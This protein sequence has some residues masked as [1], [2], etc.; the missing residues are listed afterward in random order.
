MKK[1]LW[2]FISLVSSILSFHLCASDD[3]QSKLELGQ[4]YRHDSLKFDMAGPHHKPNIISEL[5]YKNLQVYL[6]TLKG[7]ISNGTYIGVVDLAYGDIL[8]G[9]VRDSDYFHNN[10]Q[11]E[12][13]RSISKIHGDYTVDASAKIGRIFPL[14]SGMTFTP[15]VGYGAFWQN[16]HMTHAR[17]VIPHHHHFHLNSTY[18][19][20]WSAP[21][22]DF[23]FSIPLRKALSLDLGYTFFYP[24][25][26]KGKGHW[27]LRHLH[28]TQKNKTWDSYG[29][30]GDIHLRWACT[31]RLEL[32]FGV[33]VSHFMAKNGR[34]TSH[35]HSYTKKH[36]K[37]VFLFMGGNERQPAKRAE[38]TCADY[39]LS[40]SYAF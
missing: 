5:D 4:G 32:G 15:S 2:S 26:Y 9:K 33:G 19:T 34:V 16:L 22:V 3:V 25:N 1:N 39:V 8:N 6:T 24:V 38:R 40:I 18:K 28:F 11:G 12:F 17:Q 7:T 30:K 23:R 21:F 20:L 31:D 36:G 14:F 29:Q 37:N 27:N 35:Q 10:K 13:S